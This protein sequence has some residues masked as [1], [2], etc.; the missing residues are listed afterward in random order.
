MTIPSRVLRACLVLALWWVV[1]DARA[2]D[3][4]TLVPLHAFG[5][6]DGSRPG[7][8]VEGADGNL[9]GETFQGSSATEFY[10]D[11]TVFRLT[12]GGMFLTLHAFGPFTSS[13]LTNVDGALPDGLVQAA[14]GNLYGVTQ[15]GGSSGGGTA[16]RLTT[17][18][19]LSGLYPFPALDAT[20][21][22]S[23]GSHPANLTLG[24]DG[25]L[26]GTTFLGGANGGGTV[27][28]L[29]TGGVLTPLM[30][31][32]TP[33]PL[34]I[35]G[36][37]QS[38]VY[39]LPLASVTQGRDGNLYGVTINGGAN[40]LGMVFSVTPAGVLTTLHDFTKPVSGGTN[41]DGTG[42]EGGL[43]EGAD[44]RF[45]GTTYY[46]GA[47][48]G[49]TVY[50]ITPVG[51]LTTLYDFEAG[52]ALGHNANGKSPAAALMLA[53]DGNFYGTTQGGGPTGL[54]TIF[55]ITPDGVFTVLYRVTAAD[56]ITG[57]ISLL[58]SR[59]GDFYVIDHGVPN[60][61]T[62][63]IYA[64]KPAPAIQPVASLA[65]IRP[66]ATV[67]ISA[68]AAVKVNLSVPPMRNVVVRYTVAGSAVN[69]TDDAALSGAVKI[70]AGQTSA[71]IY[72][73]PQGA[74]GGDV[75]RTVKI[76]LAAGEKYTVGRPASAKVKLFAAAP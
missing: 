38:A 19:G 13:S 2:Q 70:K 43:T 25:D 5:G 3:V 8:L 54:G 32:P 40:G 28:R 69:G 26:Y 15:T 57:A 30:S 37:A 22:N 73:T 41:S 27:F 11:G 56:P 31:L 36:S 62:G 34:P 7:N 64:L 12:P 65:V 45:Y 46:G 72:V 58:Q 14:D 42:P 1:S 16:F 67:G 29:T 48:G 20:G 75:R 47:Y 53:A 52:D 74:L 33:P 17:A 39:D 61:G 49:G 44:G 21:L 51:N 4:Y 68:S 18:G 71:F 24:R 10:N 66:R 23:V 50:A 35:P 59:A 55:S 76:T 63:A 60:G 9:Y 6:A